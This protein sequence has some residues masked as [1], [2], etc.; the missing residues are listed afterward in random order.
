MEVLNT[1]FEG[2]KLI[3][4]K[5]FPDSRGC[6]FEFFQSKKYLALGITEPLVQINCSF[7]FKNVLRGL[8]YQK[9]HPQDKLVMVLEGKVLD[10]IVDIRPDSVSF[11]KWLSFELSSEN[12]HQLYIPKGF[13]HGFITLS[14]H[15]NFIYAC[16]EYYNPSSEAGIRWNDPILNISWPIDNPILSD[17]DQKLPYWQEI[18]FSI[19]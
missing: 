12:F 3:K 9:D 7:S 13:A 4:P 16:T 14:D 10:V 2:L 11:G 1:D 19:L 17:K 8:H 18:D 5:I 6:F 15:V